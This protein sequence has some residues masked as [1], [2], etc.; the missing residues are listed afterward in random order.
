MS[1]KTGDIKENLNSKIKMK[2]ENKNVKSAQKKGNDKCYQKNNTYLAI[3]HHMQLFSTKCSKINDNKKSFTSTNSTSNCH[4]IEDNNT[5]SF[6]KNVS[7][8][9]NIETIDSNN[10]LHFNEDF[11]LTHLSSH[12]EILNKNESN[13]LSPENIQNSLSS[14]KPY[15]INNFNTVSSSNCNK[16]EDTN[17]NEEF[18]S[19]NNS[20]L[21]Q[22]WNNID[23]SNCMI[24]MESASNKLSSSIPNYISKMYNKNKNEDCIIKNTSQEC[25]I[26]SCLSDRLSN[27]SEDGITF[28]EDEDDSSDSYVRLMYN[29]EL[30]A[31]RIGMILSYLDSPQ[32]IPPNVELNPNTGKPLPQRKMRKINHIIN[33]NINQNKCLKKNISLSGSFQH[34]HYPM[35][36]GPNSQYS[37]SKNCKMNLDNPKT[38]EEEKEI[39]EILIVDGRGVARERFNVI[40]AELPFKTICL[41]PSESFNP[42][43]K[44]AIET[45]NG[46]R[47]YIDSMDDSMFSN[48]VDISIDKNLNVNI[49]KACN[50]I[51]RFRCPIYDSRI[52]SEN[53]FYFL[54]RSNVRI[55]NKERFDKIL[56]GVLEDAKLNNW[57]V[58]MLK[59]Y[60]TVT[61]S[62]VDSREPDCK[63]ISRIGVVKDSLPCCHKGSYME[64]TILPII[65][66]INEKY[67][68]I[69]SQSVYC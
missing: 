3:R 28:S 23:E 33:D 8:F 11:N 32:C 5:H 13:S 15:F 22:N 40:Y 66:I 48:D 25:H 24:G 30:S 9:S 69:N 7:S 57:N 62:F 37:F 41:G 6:S 35:K 43:Q 17:D 42:F 64:I 29:R 46:E 49:K 36:L 31:T 2:E 45:E 27:S 39:F 47:Y 68:N 54:E 34:Y 51:C 67:K 65:N 53:Y 38:P 50:C 4:P 44:Q 60:A 26:S 21:S 58:S 18:K 56:P 19:K 16:N 52:E 20:T 63:D 61:I 55:F 12:N 1:D 10:V 14:S 59:K